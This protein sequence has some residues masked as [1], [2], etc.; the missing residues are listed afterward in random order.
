MFEVRCSIQ[1]GRLQSTGH[2]TSRR[3]AE[4]ESAEKMLSILS[5][6]GAD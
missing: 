5:A 4:Q 1:N 6:E 2:G 3:N